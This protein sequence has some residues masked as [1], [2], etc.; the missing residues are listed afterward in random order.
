MVKY[1]RCPGRRYENKVLVGIKVEKRLE[2]FL[3]I[4]FLNY[5]QK[6]SMRFNKNVTRH[7]VSHI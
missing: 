3:T 7:F 6:K 5:L 1:K 2:D 4:A